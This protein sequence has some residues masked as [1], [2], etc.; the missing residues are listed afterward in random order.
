MDTNGSSEPRGA[1][2]LRVIRGGQATPVPSRS[3][4]VWPSKALSVAE[5]DLYSGPS[6]SLPDHINAWRKANRRNLAR[7]IRK[8]LTARA[9]GLPTMYGQLFLTAIRGDGTVDEYGLASL[10]LV[11]TVGAR[12]ICDDFNAGTTD[13]TNF[14]FHGFG[15]G[16]TAEAVGDTILITEETTQYAVDN[17][18]PTGSQASA[19]VTTNATY[20]TVATYSPDSGATRAI[21]EHGIFSQAATGVASATNVLLD[22]SQFAAVNLVAAADSLQ[23]TYVFTVVAGS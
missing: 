5:I 3:L 6:R 10:R 7:G 14:K 23:A 1:L 11:T 22:R 17:V 21:T 2:A 13:I 9:F 12:F 19:T 8:V 18:R 15:T 16:A 20:T 4:P